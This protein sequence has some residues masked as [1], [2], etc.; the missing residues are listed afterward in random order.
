MKL[1]IITYVSFVWWKNSQI[2]E[3][4]KVQIL[5]RLGILGATSTISTVLNCEKKRQWVVSNVYWMVLRRS[6]EREF[7]EFWMTLQ[8]KGLLSDG[9][10]YSKNHLRKKSQKW[11]M[12]LSYMILNQQTDLDLRVSWIKRSACLLFQ[13]DLFYNNY[14]SSQWGF[15]EVLCN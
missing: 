1:L 7:Q 9:T 3:L 2:N 8:S 10:T 6:V 15:E 14:C 12:E 11:L 4:G 5:R 13:S